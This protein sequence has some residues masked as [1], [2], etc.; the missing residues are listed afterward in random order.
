MA[1]LYTDIFGGGASI[2]AY[3]A[4]RQLVKVFLKRLASTTNDVKMTQRSRLY[5]LLLWN[6][7]SQSAI[8]DLTVITFNQD[9]QVEKALDVIASAKERRS[10]P[11]FRFPACYHIDFD[12]TTVPDPAGSI[13]TFPVVE[14]GEE[15]VAILKLHGSMNWYSAHNSPNPTRRKLFDPQ[16]SI[17]LTTRKPID[18]SMKLSGSRVGRAKFTFPIVVPPVVHKS[19]VLHE[20]L[21]P[22]WDLAELRLREAQRVVIIGYS[23]PPTDWESANLI[24]RALNANP[25]RMEVSIIDP[26]PSVVLRFKELGNLSSLSYFTSIDRYLASE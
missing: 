17:R 11:M 9:L 8:E 14:D 13:D 10:L 16:R 25:H 24:S 6:L 21:K 26:D 7:R 18:P 1:V 2:P 4:F 22:V 23:C 3:S 19:Q 5:R 20:K 15:G 12:K